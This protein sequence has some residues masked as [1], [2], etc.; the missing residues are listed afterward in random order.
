MGYTGALFSKFYGDMFG[1][2]VAVLAL[3]T[4]CATP[5]LLGYRAFSKKDF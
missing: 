4:W 5:V 1:S 3:W 2:A